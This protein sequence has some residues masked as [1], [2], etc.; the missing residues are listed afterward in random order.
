MAAGGR[1]RRWQPPSRALRVGPSPSACAWS[2]SRAADPVRRVAP[3]IGTGTM[4]A[5]AAA[6]PGAAKTRAGP[7]RDRTGVRTVSG[8]RASAGELRPRVGGTAAGRP[9][10]IRDAVVGE[11]RGAPAGDRIGRDS[12]ADFTFGFGSTPDDDGDGGP[13]AAA[14]EHAEQEEGNFLSG[15][16]Q[17]ASKRSNLGR[18]G[19]SPSR[20]VAASVPSVNLRMH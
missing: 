4:P 14:H 6:P 7:M 9:G 1:G 18:A 13:D 10:R 17:R 8:G 19:H 5:V 12:H 15:Q 16:A 11:R 3:P 20:N 2:A